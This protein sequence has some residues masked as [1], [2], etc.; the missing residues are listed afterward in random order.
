LSEHARDRLN[1]AMQPN[2]ELEVLSVSDVSLLR[3]RMRRPL[4]GSEARIGR[5]ADR[6]IERHARE[7]AR[8]RFAAL[9]DAGP[10]GRQQALW[11]KLMG[12]RPDMLSNIVTFIQRTRRRIVE[13]PTPSR[14]SG[15][16]SDDT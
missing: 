11:A 5:Q 9:S 3:V 2:H 15:A 7:P 14:R 8:R 6:G 12:E 10:D 13:P 4:L 1:F 16:R